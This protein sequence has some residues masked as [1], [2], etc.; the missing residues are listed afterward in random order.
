MDNLENYDE[1]RERFA[2]D[3]VMCERMPD[4]LS[5]AMGNQMFTVRLK[6]CEEVDEFV[7]FVHSRDTAGTAVEE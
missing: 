6:T 1:V 4:I 2:R 5:G 7:T 3:I